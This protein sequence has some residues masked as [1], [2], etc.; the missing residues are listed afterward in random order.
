MLGRPSCEL[1]PRGQWRALLA[2]V[3]IACVVSCAS[4]YADEFQRRVALVIGNSSYVNVPRL[5]NPASDARLIASTLSEL[6]FDLIGKRALLDLDK[7]G[8]ERA[9]RQFGQAI[10]E[11]TAALFYHSGHGVQIQGVNYL[12]P[13]NADVRRMA[14]VDFV[15][16][17]SDLVLRQMEQSRSSLNIII[18]DACRTNPFGGRGLR[19]ADA[20]LAQMRVPVGT[21]ISY[22][23]Q[24]GSVADDGPPGGH[25][26]YSA[27]LAAALQIPGLDVLRMFNRVGVTVR[28]STGQ[29][30]WVSASPIEGDFYFAGPSASPAVAA[31]PSRPATPE[32]DAARTRPQDQS[33]A[34]RTEPTSPVPSPPPAVA[35]AVPAAQA[36]SPQPT[37]PPPSAPARLTQPAPVIAPAT[38]TE[39][40]ASSP[41]TP[42]APSVGPSQQQAALAPPFMPS[43]P[44]PP[45][46]GGSQLPFPASTFA[47]LLGMDCSGPVGGP[48]TRRGWSIVRLTEDQH[49]LFVTFWT[50]S[51]TRE[52]WGEQH[53]RDDWQP[54]TRRPA[55]SIEADGRM[56]FITSRNSY[57]WLQV[58]NGSLTGTYMSGGGG[59]SYPV[60]LTC[61]AGDRRP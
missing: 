29:T 39:R 2:H 53:P 15:L 58:R 19:G 45:S 38:T 47:G 37:V 3:A 42:S 54:D 16:I 1:K 32:A 31:P 46:S 43:R 52:H 4:A 17:N 35:P 41:T 12:I 48:A 60:E 49:Q 44:A 36:A 56:L 18:L 50:S 40:P 26:P 27:A 59:G 21:V 8:M 20:G 33:F 10:S 22:A 14:D 6:G 61:V 13:V 30:P 23:T 5:D 55:Q 51:S 7:D 34:T 11:N 9:I 25:S 57:Y 24:P 28:S